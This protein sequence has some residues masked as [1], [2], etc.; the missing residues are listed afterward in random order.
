LAL[1]HQSVFSLHMAQVQV[2]SFHTLHY[3]G[4]QFAVRGKLALLV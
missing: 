1:V 2:E 4:K 3:F